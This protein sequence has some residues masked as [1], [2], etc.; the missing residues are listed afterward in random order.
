ME[1]VPDHVRTNKSLVPPSPPKKRDGPNQ[2][3]DTVIV[4]TTGPLALTE[5]GTI[6]NGNFGIFLIRY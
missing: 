5:S 6:L 3:A 2:A 4:E 1:L